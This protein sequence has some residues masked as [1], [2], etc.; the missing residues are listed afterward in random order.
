MFLFGTAKK[1]ERENREL[2]LK[3]T[4]L[5]KEREQSESLIKD[6]L[7]KLSLYEQNP[8]T[9][10]RKKLKVALDKYN[11]YK[12]AMKRHYFPNDSVAEEL[13]RLIG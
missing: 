9:I 8:T 12:L 7:D 3:A 10:R 1:F 2:K 6:V 4:L 13:K 5:I 11:E